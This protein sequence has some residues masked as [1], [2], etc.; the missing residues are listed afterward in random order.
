M[1]QASRDALK[2]LRELVN[3][4][5]EDGLLWAPTV[6]DRVKYLQQE[7][8]KLHAAIEYVTDWETKEP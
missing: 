5:A 1:D 4:Q 3:K 6:N 2:K 8:R 7:L